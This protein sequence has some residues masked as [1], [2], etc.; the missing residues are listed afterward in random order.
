MMQGTAKGYVAGQG[1]I[2]KRSDQPPSEQKHN[3][4]ARLIT[5]QKT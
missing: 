1:K 3:D 4:E 2:C 5:T